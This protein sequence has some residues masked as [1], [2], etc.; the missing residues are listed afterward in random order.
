MIIKVKKPYS[1]IKG[2]FKNVY[3]IIGTAYAGKSTMLKML[4]EKYNGI[5]LRE[6]YV[7][8][9]VMK[10]YGVNKEDQPNLCYFETMSS[11]D[12]FVNR[13]PEEY[14]NWIEGC[15]KESTPIE[16]NEIL[17]TVEKYPD[18]K[19]F[20]D[21]SIPIE[22]LREISDKNHVLV[23][24][25]D[26]EES[27]NRFFEREDK[28]KQFIYQVLLKSPNSNA[29]DNYRKILERINSK[30]VYD[31]YYNSG[32]NVLLKDNN[33]KVEDTLVLVED[34]FGL[35]KKIED[36]NL[37]MICKEVNEVAFRDLSDE[38]IIRN[39][40]KEELDI[41]KK[42]PFDTDDCVEGIAYMSEYYDKVYKKHEDEFFKRCLF[43]C[44]KNDKPL[45]TCFL[46][47]SYGKVNTIH[48]LKVLKEYENLGLGRMLLTYIMKSV[49][50]Y[51]VYLH[52][53]P[54]SFRAIK[55]YSDFG[56]EL[57]TDEKIGNRVNQLKESLEYL[58]YNM[59]D[60]YKKLKFT[61]SDG[62]LD[63]I[64]SESGINEF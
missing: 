31:K 27:V 40:R 38:Y 15:S 61:R 9:E 12:E 1:E 32:F 22:V 59:K 51:P 45:G 21:T 14:V 8:D 48:W 20:V 44:D 30:E 25:C 18:K 7:D 42:F 16:I 10:R 64:A 17:N 54:G 24:L 35:N 41:W 33:R 34:L 39:I 37:F 3:F 60:N 53:Q 55:L 2:L 46:W 6:N 43:I 19:V 47:K 5:L 50:E 58:K 4:S 28:E 63:K 57:L 49:D 13:T 56:F 36:Y 52:T 23:M 26:R 62:Y 29:L 11:W